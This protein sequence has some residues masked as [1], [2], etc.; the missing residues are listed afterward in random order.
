VSYTLQVVYQLEIGDVDGTPAP[1]ESHQRHRNSLDHL[2]ELQRGKMRLP[3]WNNMEKHMLDD[4]KELFQA[5]I[6]PQFEGLKGDMRA[7]ESKID[8]L[9]SKFD[10]KINALD[11]K[12]EAKIGA[13][14]SKFDAKFDALEMKL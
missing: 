9:D 13:L 8:A 10:A 6:L 7:L 12:F 5:F 11:S 4:L 1:A 14:D 3:L 2:L